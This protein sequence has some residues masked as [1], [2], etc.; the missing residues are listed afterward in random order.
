M[1]EL[2]NGRL[3]ENELHQLFVLYELCRPRVVVSNVSCCKWL[4]HPYFS[5]SCCKLEC[6]NFLKTTNS[7]LYRIHI[8]YLISKCYICIYTT[9]TLVWYKQLF[10]VSRKFLHYKLKPN[11]YAIH[12]CWCLELWN[13]VMIHYFTNYKSSKIFII[14]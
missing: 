2:F 14:P 10:D 7:S 5:F 9:I 13:N 12:Q 3:L 6:G 4:L 11:V 8:M 1:C